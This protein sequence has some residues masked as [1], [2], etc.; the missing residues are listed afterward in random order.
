MCCLDNAIDACVACW[1]D[2][3][4]GAASGAPGGAVGAQS[5]L[6]RYCKRIRRRIAGHALMQARP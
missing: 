1:M 3:G 6:G 4:V 2:G 5:D